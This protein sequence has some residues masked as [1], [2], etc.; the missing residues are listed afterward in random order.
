MAPLLLEVAIFVWVLINTCCNQI[1]GA[2]IHGWIFSM[3]AYYPV[4][5][6]TTATSM[7]LLVLAFP[8]L[9]IPFLNSCPTKPALSNTLSKPFCV[10][11]EHSRYSTAPSSCCISCPSEYEMGLSLFSASFSIVAESSRRSSFV[12]TRMMGVSGQLCLTS[13]YHYRGQWNM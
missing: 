10:S 5:H 4:V 8:Q 9:T 12:P 13:G 3:G 6:E 1:R 7:C 2:Y 11:A